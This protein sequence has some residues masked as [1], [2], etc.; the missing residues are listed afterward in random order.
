M[1]VN[2]FRPEIWSALLLQALRKQLVYNVFTNSDYEGE[3]EESGDTVRITT[4]GRPT[5]GTYVPNVTV[6]TPETPKESQRTLVVDQSKYFAVAVDDVDARQ[7]KGNIMPTLTDEAGFGFA[8]VIDQYI[9]SFY[10]SIQS[11]NQLGS[12]GVNSATTPSDAYDKVLVPLRVKL[13][14]ANVPNR[15]RSAVITPDMHGCLI[16]DQRFVSFGTQDNKQVL[17][18]GLVGRAAGFDIYLSNNTPNTTGQ[19]FAV[20]AGNNRAITFANQ[21]NKMEAYRPQSS[22]ADAVKGLVLYGAKNVRPDSLASALV[23]VS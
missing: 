9:A 21:I 1:S 5:I 3:I 17:T 10:T 19:E 16:R 23:T 12:I 22:F 8:D 20:M 4:I 18:E 7:A 14:K 13:D 11:A 15:G 2:K 6:I